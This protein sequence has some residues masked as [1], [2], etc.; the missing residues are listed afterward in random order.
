MAEE[1]SESIKTQLA[2]ALAQGISIASWARTKNVPRPTVYRWAREPEVRKE[3]EACRRQILDRA[4]GKL[5][6]N[7]NFAVE[8]IRRLA[9]TA[10]SES[11]QLKASRSMLLDNVVVTKFSGWDGRLAEVEEQLREYRA[12]NENRQG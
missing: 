3:V 10:E 5:T 7:S 2:I 6:K 12:G 11:V 8:R 4:I 9:E 1:Q